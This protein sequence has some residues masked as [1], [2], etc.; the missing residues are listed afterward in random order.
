MDSVEFIGPLFGQA[1]AA[2][3]SSADA[4]VLPSRSEGLPMAVLEAWS[5]A[6]PV[7]ITTACNLTEGVTAG[8]AIETEPTRTSIA[9]GLARLAKLDSEGLDAMGRRGRELVEARFSWPK[10]AADLGRV[11]AAVAAGRDLPSE[12]TSNAA[13]PAK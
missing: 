3:L 13:V 5:H 11:Y 7:L 9:D 8:A 4:F 10:I 1:K 6:K 2:A 12:L